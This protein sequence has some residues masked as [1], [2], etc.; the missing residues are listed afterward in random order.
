MNRQINKSFVGKSIWMGV[1]FIVILVAGISVLRGYQLHIKD[2]YDQKLS[3]ISTHKAMLFNIEQIA[4]SALFEGRGYLAFGKDPF[5][6]QVNEQER[7]LEDELKLFF[8]H[9]DTTDEQQLYNEFQAFK[10]WYFDDAFPK[11]VQY[12]KEKNEAAIDKVADD[13]GG[14]DKVN[15]FLALLEEENKK[16]Q[17]KYEQTLSEKEKKTTFAQTM[18][19]LFLGMMVLVLL[20]LFTAVI[21]QVILPLKG[22]A[23]TAS[24]ISHGAYIDSL[25]YTKRDDEIGA[26]SRSL[27][28]MI[29]DLQ[30]NEQ[31]LMAQNEELLAQQDELNEQQD[32]LQQAFAKTKENEEALLRRNQ[33]IRA[34][35]NTLNKCELLGNVMDSM[36]HFTKATKGIIVLMD[37]GKSYASHG[38]V[39]KEEHQFLQSLDESSIIAKLQTSMKPYMIKRESSSSERGY[40]T[41]PYYYYDLIL[42]IV[43]D[44]KELLAVIM[45]SRSGEGFAEKE[46][47]EYTG[48]CQQ[49]SLSLEKLHMYEEA[50]NSRQTVQDILNTIHEG[51]QLFDEEGRILLVNETLCD[52][53][54]EESEALLQKSSD[55]WVEL[56]QEKVEEPEGL[57]EFIRKAIHQQPQEASYIFKLR[58]GSTQIIQLY[59]ETLHREDHKFGT[60]FV[61][62]DITK[63]YEV[64]QMKSEFVSTVS[65]ELRTPLSSVLGFTELML[66]KELPPQRQRKYLMTISQEASRLTALIN[67]FLDVQRMESGKQ[68]YNKNYYSI[69]NVVEDVL[70]MNKINTNIHDFIVDVQTKKLTILG[71]KDKLSQVFNN[72]LSNAVKYSPNGGKIIVRIREEQSHLK[73]DV[74]DEGL[75]IPEESISHLFTKFYR[76]DN[77]D[78]RKIGGTGLGLAIVKEI[79]KAHDGDIHVQSQFGHGSTFTVSF[80]LVE[81]V[82]MIPQ[83]DS[84][85]REYKAHVVII[86]DDRSLANLLYEELKDNDFHVGHFTDGETAVSA[87]IEQ[88]PDA[89]V[90]D[91]LLDNSIDGWA[92]IKKLKEN[93]KTEKIPIF[94]STALDEQEKGQHLGADGYL[95]KPYQPSKLSNHILQVLLEN[96]RKGQIMVPNPEK[97]ESE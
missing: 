38:L 3:H 80:P 26:L 63:Q 8:N 11:V 96:E 64:D 15:S 20:A 7:R 4:D 18:F 39:E 90:V 60:I 35:A 57:I 67:D 82:S 65:H 70:T 83:V 36:V 51:I 58:N 81:D 46:I 47:E 79:V 32:K 12:K 37:E 52:M 75:G 55:D 74:I 49:I 62:R 22:L 24:Q 48:F 6:A 23:F 97:N 13:E 66:N 29:Q 31:E 85:D 30:Q 94:I 77:T 87:I 95:V 16:L 10:Q 2:E 34:L 45:V 68:T 14:T 42:P 84:T 86:E 53:M 78:R 72:L 73:V 41:D 69:Q 93:S 91:I 17:L 59:P 5:I 92:V 21:R 43:H 50:E 1:A 27:E 44:D 54:G 28:K 89:V 25:D 19:F 40:V 76:I 33:F 56:I 61:Y 88:L 71:D 9:I